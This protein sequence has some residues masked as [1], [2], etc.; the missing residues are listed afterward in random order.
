LINESRKRGIE[1]LRKGESRKG[2][3][4]AGVKNEKKKNGKGIIQPQ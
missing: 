4:W 2:G 3:I 1:V